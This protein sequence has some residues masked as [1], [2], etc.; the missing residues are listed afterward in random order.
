MDVVKRKPGRPKTNK[1]VGLT[2]DNRGLV[3]EP[4]APENVVEMVYCSAIFKQIFVLIHNYEISEI[5]ISYEKDK[6][7]F[8]N[9]ES[10]KE[11]KL[12]IDACKINLYYCKEPI[13]VV[14]NTEYLYNIFAS[15]TKQDHKITMII[16]NENYDSKL[17]ILI[18]NPEFANENRYSIKIDKN[19]YVDCNRELYAATDKYLSFSLSLKHLKQKVSE[20]NKMCDNIIVQKNGEDALQIIIDGASIVQYDSVYLDTQKIQ[21]KS[22]LE[23]DDI[24]RAAISL[25]TIGPISKISTTGNVELIILPDKNEIIFKL[26]FDKK[27]SGMTTYLYLITTIKK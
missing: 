11:F 15:L 21:L 19:D 2:V 22:T 9:K 3:Y 12:V 13:T 8:Y 17:Q 18:Y 14:I 4:S 24:L 7:I 16:T 23:E 6:I 5:T 10:D 25:S 26:G 1:T 27:D 20:T